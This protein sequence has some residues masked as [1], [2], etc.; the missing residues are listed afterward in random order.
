M[1]F[2]QGQSPTFLEDFSMK[3]GVLK[4]CEKG[5]EPL[6]LVILRTIIS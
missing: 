6:T 5:S 1:V 3:V 2:F 4:Q